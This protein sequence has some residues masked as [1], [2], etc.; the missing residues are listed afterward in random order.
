MIERSIQSG[1]TSTKD[2]PDA[3]PGTGKGLEHRGQKAGLAD[4]GIGDERQ[5]A[6]SCCISEGILSNAFSPE[7]IFTGMKNS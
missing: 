2:H 5:W 7:M 1:G 6:P 4:P 3:D